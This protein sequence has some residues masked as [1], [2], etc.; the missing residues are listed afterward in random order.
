[1]TC[2]HAMELMVSAWRG[3]LSAFDNATLNAHMAECA[4]CRAEMATLSAMWSRMGDIPVPEPGRS[5]DIRWQSTLDSL[6]AER[7]M[8]QPGPIPFRA[9][10][11]KFWPSQ[12]AWQLAVAAACLMVG[13]FVGMKWQSGQAS[14]GEIARLRQE[15]ANTKEMVALSLLQQ[16]SP[17]ERL[18]GV[19]YSTRMPS[20]EPDVVSAL[21]QAVSHDQNVN[22][23][24]AAID[25]LTRLAGDAKVRQS[26][27]QSLSTQDSPMVQAALIDYFVEAR[28]KQ[29]TGA[30]QQL[31]QRPDL[32]PAVR[33]VAGT[34]LRR[35]NEYR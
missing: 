17:S 21:I 7:R 22:V 19:D 30:V 10:V 12:P 6:I 26:L 13:L 24:L 31:M 16:Q 27:T 33:T 1:M 14:N 32:N 9:K 4:A 35:L 8:S 20:M 2:D 15:V 34:A 25:A 3:E 5:L 28:D 23:R 29:A 11:L 18:R